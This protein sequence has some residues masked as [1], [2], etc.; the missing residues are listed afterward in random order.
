MSRRDEERVERVRRQLVALL[1]E[2]HLLS[3][4]VVERMTRCGKP[5]CHCQSSRLHGPYYQWGYGKGGRRYTRRLS[6]DQFERYG[7]E[8]ERSRRFLE[9]LSDFD[10]AEISRV[11]RAEGWKS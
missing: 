8:I 7:P 3:G 2:G 1:E 6:K 4:G 5:N 11:E 10:E 9:L